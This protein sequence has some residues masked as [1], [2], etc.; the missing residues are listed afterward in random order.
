MRHGVCS[1]IACEG[2]VDGAEVS[3]G[4]S[5]GGN[6][7]LPGRAER[8]ELIVRSGISRDVCDDRSQ[9]TTVGV[10]GSRCGGTGESGNAVVCA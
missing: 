1:G 3:R 5:T 6:V 9:P 7:L 8:W 4:R 2:G 10:W